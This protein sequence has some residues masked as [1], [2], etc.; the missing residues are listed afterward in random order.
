MTKLQFLKMEKVC[1]D[2]W[3]ALAR[4]GDKKKSKEMGIFYCDCPSCEIDKRLGNTCSYC[5]ILTWRNNTRCV[6]SNN[7]GLFDQWCFGDKNKRQHAAKQIASLK[8]SWMTAYKDAELSPEI[9]AYLRT[10]KL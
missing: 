10:V 1:K 6:S 9:L 4:S 8:W 2:E 7:D 3:K 5:P